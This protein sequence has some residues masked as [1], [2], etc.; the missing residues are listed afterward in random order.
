MDKQEMEMK[1]KWKCN[2]LD[3]LLFAFVPRALIATSVLITCFASLASFCRYF[4]TGKY[5]VQQWLGIITRHLCKIGSGYE[6]FICFTYCKQ[7]KLEFREG[8]GMRL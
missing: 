7:S 6:A 2:L 5:W 4:C 3:V 8:L 1:Q